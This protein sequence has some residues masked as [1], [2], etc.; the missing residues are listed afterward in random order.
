MN[1]ASGRYD[2][3]IETSEEGER[4]RER[5]IAAIPPFFATIDVAAPCALQLYQNYRVP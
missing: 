5:L 1:G 2:L 3:K 4:T